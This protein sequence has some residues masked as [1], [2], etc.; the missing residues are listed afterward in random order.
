MI[1]H[2]SY[3]VLLPLP[4]SLLFSPPSLFPPH[5]SLVESWR[6]MWQAVS[7]NCLF[8]WF[9]WARD[10]GMHDILI[11]MLFLW[12]NKPLNCR[13]VFR[14]CSLVP[15]SLPSFRRMLEIACM[16]DNLVSFFTKISHNQKMAKTNRQYCWSVYTL[17]TLY[18]WP[19]FS[20]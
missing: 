17:N 11:D 9:R 2:S 6:V 12:C 16:R 1:S 7:K 15:R 4:F 3:I 18:V 19:V 13:E 14:L 5:Q 20:P 8:P 10:C